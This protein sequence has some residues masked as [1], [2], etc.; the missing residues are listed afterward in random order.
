V[1][2]SHTEEAYRQVRK[3]LDLNEDGS[4]TLTL[5]EATEVI[6]AILLDIAHAAVMKP[7]QVFEMLARAVFDR[8]EKQEQ[9]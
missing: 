1:T 8:M 9:S 4:G 3:A 2:G 7:S 5:T 6:A